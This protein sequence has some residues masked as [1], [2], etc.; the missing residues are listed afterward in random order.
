MERVRV[1]RFGVLGPVLVADEAGA[2]V[3]V[4]GGRLRV[5]LA[6]LV[7][8]ANQVVPVD[9][10]AEIIW[11]GAPSAEGARTVRR[12]VVRLR[13]ALGPVLAARIVTRAPGYACQAGADEVDLLLF[14]MLCRQGGEAVR[15]M[16]WPRAAE[17]LGEALALWRGAPLADAGSR[18]L[19]DAHVPRL[20]Q[21]RLQALEW[22][23]EADLHLGRHDQVV[24]ELAALASEHPL[25]EHIHSQLMLALYRSG[26]RGEALAAY[27]DARRVLVTELGVEPAAALRV[28][29]QQ[30]LAAD[31]ALA[32][33][34]PDDVGIAAAGD[35]GAARAR[36]NSGLEGG[37]GAADSTASVAGFARGGV[38][39][40]RQL[41]APVAHFTGRAGALQALT[42]MA[43]QATGTG[44]AV[45]IG[46]AAGIGKT[47]LAVQW[48]QQHA[49]LFPDGQLY[50]NLR[51]FDP[52][53]DPVQPGTAI[54]GFLQALGMAAGEIPADLAAQAGLYRSLV[55]GRRMLIVLDNASN[56]EQVRPLLPGS[57]GC[58]VLV[59]SRVQL[60]GLVAVN[61]ARPL[62]LDLLTPVEARDLL[63]RRLGD[64]G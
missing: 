19:M 55:A 34:Q 46:G 30:I 59:T 35:G 38:A 8:R 57:A 25:R 32:P 58:L 9:E 54:R 21:L 44:G 61:G 41:P 4:V 62:M 23:I 13:R 7:V 31:P 48:G 15:A 53:G 29:H 56:D 36:S 28:V 17:L 24:P 22:R 50:V 1:V 43:G 20:Q 63:A 5:L 11:D 12:Y 37:E 10:L 3:P 45:V 2:E 42:T 64:P 40:P 60:T 26:R 18:V 49:D 33:P 14:E 51:G 16:A 6:A 27:Q 39:V 52:A 47:A